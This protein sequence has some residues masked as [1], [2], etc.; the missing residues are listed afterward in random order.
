MEAAGL[1]VTSKYQKQPSRGVLRRRCSD[2]CSKFKGEH[3]CRSAISINL[4]S[5]FIEITVGFLMI[6]GRIKVNQF[7]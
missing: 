5:I 6:S 1:V 4:Q 7:A 3:P 2:I